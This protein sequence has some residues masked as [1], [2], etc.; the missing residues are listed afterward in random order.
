MAKRIMIRRRAGVVIAAA[1]IALDQ[2]IKNWVE[3]SLGF[4]DP[5]PVLPF[6]ALYRTWNEGIAFSFLSFM[7]DWSLMV[8][9]FLITLFVMWLW[10]N[11][12]RT[13]W[14]AQLGFSMVIG[15]AIGNLVDRA[16]LGHVVDYILFH[17]GDW[18][19]A[20]F[21]LADA[22]ITVGA[23]AIILDELV[24][25]MKGGARQSESEK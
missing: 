13:R 3:T 21:N 20:I 14:L 6:L 5:L 8:F 4:Q 22:C 17:V 23:A 19:F 16:F 10:K 24:T 7:D 18:S 2:A 9:T 11:T 1:I 25:G 15:G 12:P